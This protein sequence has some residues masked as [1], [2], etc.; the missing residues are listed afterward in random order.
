MAEPDFEHILLFFI[1]FIGAQFVVNVL[2]AIGKKPD[3]DHS[4]ETTDDEDGYCEY[5]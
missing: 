4:D 2:N 1:F 3:G 5:E